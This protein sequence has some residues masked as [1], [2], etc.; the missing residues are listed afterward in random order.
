VV[1]EA[2][3][4]DDAGRSLSDIPRDHSGLTQAGV[5]LPLPDEEDLAAVIVEN[6]PAGRDGGGLGEEDLIPRDHSG[7]AQANFRLPLAAAEEGRR[8]RVLP[9]V[10]REEE[11][12][13]ILLVGDEPGDVEVLTGRGRSLDPAACLEAGQDKGVC[14]GSIPSFSYDVAT[15]TCQ[16]FV[17]SGCAGSANRFSSLQECTD[18]CKGQKLF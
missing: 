16:E 8:S 5:R 14:R 3:R 13:E 9:G 11:E 15:D 12:A 7:L 6:L 4:T 18:L 2:D 17:Y 1:I 10:A